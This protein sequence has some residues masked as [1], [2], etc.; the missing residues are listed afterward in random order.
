M[1]PL[2]HT[3]SLLRQRMNG[4]PINQ[5]ERTCGAMTAAMD[6]QCPGRGM[7]I[8][9]QRAF[10]GEDSDGK[11]KQKRFRILPNAIP[12]LSNKSLERGHCGRT[13]FRCQSEAVRP[14]PARSAIADSRR[15]FIPLP[16]V[17]GL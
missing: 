10:H 5:E 6:D 9:I 13:V 7:G 11:R 4:F 14:S 8:V 1:C 2:P 12:P 16:F 17:P 3:P 15:S